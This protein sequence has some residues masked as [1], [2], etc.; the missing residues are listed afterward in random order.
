MHDYYQ[1][2]I[3]HSRKEC[4]VST[5]YVRKSNAVNFILWIAHSYKIASKCHDGIIDCD[6][7]EFCCMNGQTLFLIPYHVGYQI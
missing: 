6:D 1:V 4:H 3:A 2:N 7:R 5:L